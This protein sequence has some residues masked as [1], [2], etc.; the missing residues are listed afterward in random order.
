MMLDL[1]SRPPRSLGESRSP[2]YKK[3]MALLLLP[4]VFLASCALMTGYDPIS[5]KT[6]T[7]LKA[8]SLLLMDKATQAPDPALLAKIDD[9]RVKLSQAYE[10]EKGKK[11]PNKITVEQWKLLNDPDGNLLGGFLKRWEGKQGT[12]NG[13]NPDF[14]TQAKELVKDAFNEIIKLEGEKVG[15]TN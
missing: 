15:N 11:G 14:V 4:I 7:D 3:G 1:I 5:Y 12:G 13:L 10:Y 6:A 9:M 8:E 2:S